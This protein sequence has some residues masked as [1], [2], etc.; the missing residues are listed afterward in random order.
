M[1][2][3]SAA[4]IGKADSVVPAATYVHGGAARGLAINDPLEQDDVIRTSANGSTRVRFL[5]DTMLTVGPNAEIR[6]DKGVFDGSQART[7]SVEVI[8][9][10]MRFVS[11]V[12]S[13]N[14]YEIKT[15]VATIG[16]RGTVVD[17]AHNGDRTIVNFVDGSGPICM[18]ATA[19][20]RTC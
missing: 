13:R 20:C 4:P 1:A 18:G 17:I 10:A 15:P 6:L 3:A 9:G 14:S 8:S 2:I 16:V 19:E 5:D 11:G 7:L 12:S